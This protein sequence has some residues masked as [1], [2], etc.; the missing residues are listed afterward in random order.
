MDT[1]LARRSK[2]NSKIDQGR[3]PE[4]SFT[5]GYG[6]GMAWRVAWLDRRMSSG[7]YGGYVDVEVEE[8]VA[9]R[10]AVQ[11]GFL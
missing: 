11:R 8:E 2:R 5:K 10:A 4:S 1:L 7:G 6:V 3:A 9:E